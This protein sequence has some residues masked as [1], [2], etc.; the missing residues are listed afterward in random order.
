MSVHINSCLQINS[1]D[2]IS[3]GISWERDQSAT[4]WIRPFIPSF[5]CH[6]S[7]IFIHFP[8][9]TYVPLGTV[10]MEIV[11]GNCPLNRKLKPL[12][13]IWTLQIWMEREGKNWD[14]MIG[15]SWKR[16][17]KNLSILSPFFRISFYFPRKERVRE[18]KRGMNEWRPEYQSFHFLPSCRIIFH[19]FLPS[20]VCNEDRK[21]E[22]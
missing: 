5:R 18:R 10:G 4:Q 2:D 8:V 7:F 19:L 15:K 6:D 13:S 17:H 12:L 22:K 9:L 16:K 14:R 11:R 20:F 21:N 1:R 3:P